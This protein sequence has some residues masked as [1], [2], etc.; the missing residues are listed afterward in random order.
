[1]LASKATAQNPAGASTASTPAASYGYDPNY[2]DYAP[3][4]A[5]RPPMPAVWLLVGGIAILCLCCGILIGGIL[6][7][8]IG[9]GPYVLFGAPAP[10]PSPTPEGM[11][12][13][14]SLFRF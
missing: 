7:L 12:L 6:G 3:S 5:R 11:N 13:I 1:M 8:G 4:P 10:P 9:P 14:I 2:Y